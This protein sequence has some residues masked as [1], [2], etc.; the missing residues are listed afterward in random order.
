VLQD[1]TFGV[2][3]L[4]QK[5]N[6]F[7]FGETFFLNFFEN[8]LKSFHCFIFMTQTCKFFVHAI[9]IKK[10]ETSRFSKDQK[11]SFIKKKLIFL[12]FSSHRDAIK[13]LYIRNIK[14]SY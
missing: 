13:I 12:M 9:K 11:K 4:A 6:L 7:F 1:G 3:L 2:I 8:D 14:I 5:K 10:N